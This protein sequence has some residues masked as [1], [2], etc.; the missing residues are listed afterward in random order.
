[1][2]DRLRLTRA[3]APL[4]ALV[5]LGTADAP[6]VASIDHIPSVVRDLSTAVADFTALG[7]ILKP[8]RPHANGL[9]NA[10]VK[11][12]DGSYLELISPAAGPTDALATDYANSLKR[13]EGPVFAGFNT[14]DFAHLATRLP[15]D[16]PPEPDDSMKAFPSGSRLHPFF[17]LGYRVPAVTDRRAHYAHPNTAYSLGAVWIAASRYQRTT[18]V[19]LAGTPSEVAG[20]GFFPASAKKIR[21]T[22]G[23]IILLPRGKRS[24]TGATIL[25]RRLA[26]AAAVLDRNRIAYTQVSACPNSLWIAPGAAHGIALELREA[27]R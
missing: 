8:G 5:A 12:P 6:I 10:H 1:M 23:E 13:G 7:F 19:G 24:I 25:V 11:F 21:L 3:A 18:L 9:R 17:F 14:T 20:C 4:A 27:Q 22:A 26:T 16:D 2:V 15:R